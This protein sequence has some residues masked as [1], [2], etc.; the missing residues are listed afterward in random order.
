MAICGMKTKSGTLCQR[1]GKHNGRCYQHVPAKLSPSS[2]SL[3]V[4]MNS[5]RKMNE[6][7]RLALSLVYPRIKSRMNAESF[8]CAFKNVNKY[9]HSNR[10]WMRNMLNYHHFNTEI[11]QHFMNFRKQ[12]I[13]LHKEL[14]QSTGLE[15]RKKIKNMI[16]FSYE[17]KNLWSDNKQY[18]KSFYNRYVSPIVEYLRH[19]LD[20]LLLFRSKQTKTNDRITRHREE[21]GR[22][23]KKIPSLNNYNVNNLLLQNS[24][25]SDNSV[26]SSINSNPNIYE[27]NSYS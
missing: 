12:F 6:S 19:H 10:N 21:L 27:N 1:E 13:L 4:K 15:R 11:E 22:I 2:R 8:R 17:N 3:P 26:H 14:I 24:N 23:L 16:S 5:E 7:T 20:F 9:T 25:S 18:K